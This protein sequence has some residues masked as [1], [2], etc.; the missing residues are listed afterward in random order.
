MVSDSE[1]DRKSAETIILVNTRKQCHLLLGE[2]G[3]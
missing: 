2:A 1:R 3:I